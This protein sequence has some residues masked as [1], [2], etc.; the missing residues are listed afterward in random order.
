MKPA[1][2]T[3]SPNGRGSLYKEVRFSP[4]PTPVRRTQSVPDTHL[5][6][7]SNYTGGPD[8]EAASYSVVSAEYLRQVRS[9]LDRQR[10]NFEHERKLFNE[11]RHLWEN[12]RALLNQRISE[13]ESLLKGRGSTGTAATSTAALPTGTFQH[14][15]SSSSSAFHSQFSHPLSADHTGSSHP[16]STQVWEGSSPGSKPTRVFPN[17]E[18]TDFSGLLFPEQ[19]GNP[20]V[21]AP[22]L[23][24]ALSP[25]SHATDLTSS[26]CVPVPIERLDSKLDGITLK[27]SALPPEIV[28]RVITP[29]SPPSLEGS[30]SLSSRPSAEHRNSLKLK[31]SE[32]GPPEFNLTRN[33]GHTPMARIDRDVDTEQPSPQETANEEEPLAS[34]APRQPAENS[35]SYF[36]DL[37]DDPALKGPLTL[38]NEEEHDSEFLKEL[39]QKLLDQVKQALGYP[40]STDQKQAEVEPPSQGDEPE[41]RFKNTTNFGTA[42]GNSDCGKV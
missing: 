8:I 21:S 11:E 41:L 5:D 13:L 2:A 7:R 32:L 3:K 20:S 40:R 36:G 33:A 17:V 24:A 42:F 19:G 34:E 26:T 10:A 25:K 9:L 18:K 38:L 4:T 22:S 1:T 6:S 15:A 23:D 37:A 14:Y 12:E 27:S 39:D 28:A 30:P 35:D 16:T 31:L 29:P